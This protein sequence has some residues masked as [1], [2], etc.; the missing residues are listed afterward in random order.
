MLSIDKEAVKKIIKNLKLF[1]NIV[2]YA[3]ILLPRKD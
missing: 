2:A 1:N 3:V